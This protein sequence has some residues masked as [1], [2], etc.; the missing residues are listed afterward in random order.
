[1]KLVRLATDNNGVFASA[2]Q[3]DMTIAPQSQ[4]ALLN[5]TFQTEYIVLSVNDTNNKIT[6]KSNSMVTG[7][8]ADGVLN[9][10]NYSRVDYNDFFNDLEYNL[11]ASIAD[12]MSTL[13]TCYSLQVL[14]C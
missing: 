3:N 11:N 10:L 4:M 2:F 1:M 9:Q 5:L 13:S 14:F 6:F 8:Q 7:T 12:G